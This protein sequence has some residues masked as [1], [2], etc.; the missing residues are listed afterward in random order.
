MIYPWQK[1]QWH[2]LTQARQFH[3]LPHALLLTGMAGVGKADFAIHLA[4]AILCQ[5]QTPDSQPCGICHACRLV[6]GRAHPNLLC[7]SPEKE[8]QAIKVDQIREVMDFANQS[9]LQGEY[10]IVII[11]P[12]DAMNISAANALLKTLE[13]PSSGAI[14]VLVSD[15]SERMPATILSRC[16]RVIFG[17]PDK[18]QALAWL[19]EQVKDTTM[20]LALLLSLANGAPLAA[21]DLIQ[22]DSLA[23][24]K[25]F[26]DGLQQLLDKQVDPIKL[27]G[28][29]SDLEPLPLIDFMLTWLTDLMQLHL[30][31]S[32]CSR[33]INQDYITIM[34]QQQSLVTL[35]HCK[36]LLD[37]LL[38][39]RAQIC[40]G[41][42]FNKQLMT[43][44]MLLRWMEYTT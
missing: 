9:S 39:Q 34:R 1:Q 19:A 29:L 2:Q 20:N 41:M 6:A 10:R 28:R 5:Q 3:R 16:Q 17:R 13:E 43:E 8:G 26:Y 24:R 30:G 4:N 42:N 32:E 38:Q 21:R 40:R 22:T 31:D 36:Q 15:Q 23:L 25:I 44:N 14:I 35:S 27:A 11:H 12:A 18:E 37:R 7:V 33:I